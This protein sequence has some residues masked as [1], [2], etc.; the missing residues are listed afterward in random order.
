LESETQ[1]VP[2]SVPQS[3][4]Q[5]VPQGKVDKE[6]IADTILHLIRDNNKITRL[7]MAA[8]LGVTEK[9]IA[10]YIKKMENIKYVGSGYSGHWEIME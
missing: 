6:K 4:L 2:Q 10:R 7:D 1:S 5:D 8:K 9:T 3:V